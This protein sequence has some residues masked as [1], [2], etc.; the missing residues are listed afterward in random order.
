MAEEKEDDFIVGM[1]ET[2]GVREHAKHPF[3]DV[4]SG[5][6]FE[7]AVIWAVENGIT[8]GT[9]ATTFSPNATCTSGEI[10]TFLWRSKGKPAAISSSSLAAKYSGKF[11][12]DAV[13][14]ADTTGLLSGT[15]TAFVPDNNSP[16]ADIVTYLYRNAGSPAVNI[17]SDETESS[18]ELEDGVYY[19]RASKNTKF[20]LDVQGDSKSYGAKF[21]IYSYHGEDNQ[22]FKVIKVG[23]NKYII[24]CFHSGKW[25][26]SSGTKGE[27]ITQSGSVTDDSAITFTIIKQADGSYRIMDRSGLYLSISDAKMANST[28]V[29]LSTEAFDESQIYIFEKID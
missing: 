5:S 7:A 2:Y 3:T 14:W 28:N 16:R 29:I 26:K 12:T 22:K 6:Y 23:E 20:L 13:A 15:G 18:D 1:K 17:Y 25:L 4:A 10:V 27:I 24:H 19:I 11:Y 9:S 8:N 21:I